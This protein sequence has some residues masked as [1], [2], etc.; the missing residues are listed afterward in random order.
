MDD[1]Y[2]Y[3]F[4]ER[5]SKSRDLYLKSIGYW[6]Q[7]KYVKAVNILQEK[8]DTEFTKSSEN[9]FIFQPDE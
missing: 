6:G 1:I 8:Q 5:G 7:K 2:E 4:I 9:I 3:Y